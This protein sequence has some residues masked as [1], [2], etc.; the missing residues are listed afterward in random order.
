M[1]KICE[2]CLFL[3]L[4]ERAFGAI[5]ATERGYSIDRIYKE[6]SGRM[7]VIRNILLKISCVS[8]WLCSWKKKIKSYETVIMNAS[9]I[10]VPVARYILRKKPDMRII[11]WYRN[12]VVK[13][14]NPDEFTRH[15]CEV[16]SFDEADC[17]KYGMQYNTQYYYNDIQQKESP[18]KFDILFIGTDKGRT[19][20]LLEFKEIF[21]HAGI[22]NYF[23]ITAGKRNVNEN[24]RYL[25]KDVIPYTKIIEYIFESKAIL[26]FVAKKQSGLTLRPLE[27]IF[28][29]KKL[30]TND[31]TMRQRDFYCMENIFILGEDPIENLKEFINSPYK[32]IDKDIVNRYD[33]D[34]WMQ[35]FFE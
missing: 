1:E 31:S 30:I 27:S 22:S 16:W 13:S 25:F 15:N 10:T 17:A 2:K 29:Q 28:F 8:P 19:E 20:K 9:A 21:D 4:S 3:W 32:P 26:D 7:I 5:K 18:I 24:Y 14:I 35:R 33:F 34:S 6:I 11:A 12:P 23:H